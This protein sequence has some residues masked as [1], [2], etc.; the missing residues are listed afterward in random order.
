[1]AQVFSRRAS[2]VG[3]LLLGAM[4]LVTMAPQLLLI[5][6]VAVMH[7]FRRGGAAEASGMP[8]ATDDERWTWSLRY[9]ALCLFLGAG[10]YFC[11]RLLSGRLI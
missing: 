2:I 10:I 1:V 3:G 8:A 6:I 5:G 9:F 7:N 4:F 11:H